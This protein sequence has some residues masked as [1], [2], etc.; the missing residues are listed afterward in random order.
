[1]LLLWSTKWWKE[2]LALF[3]VQESNSE[4]LWFQMPLENTWADV[5]RK[6]LR[7]AHNTDPSY[8][9]LRHH[10]EWNNVENV[11]MWCIVIFLRWQQTL[12]GHVHVDP[13]QKQNL[14]CKKCGIHFTST[15]AV[16]TMADAYKQTDSAILHLFTNLS[17]YASFIVCLPQ[18][19]S[20]FTLRLMHVSNQIVQFYTYLPHYLMFNP[21]FKSIMERTAPKRHATCLL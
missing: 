3:R 17:L 19:L 2:P 4:V 21:L 7:P 1:M 9:V 8:T 11:L 20:L 12:P 10:R 14:F 13:V 16:Y 5:A 15:L 6:S 18:H